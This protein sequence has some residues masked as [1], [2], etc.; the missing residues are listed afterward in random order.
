[1]LSTPPPRVVITALSIIVLVSGFVIFGFLKQWQ[2]M[3]AEGNFFWKA[4]RTPSFINAY[5][6]G[7]TQELAYDSVW[8]NILNLS[9]AGIWGKFGSNLYH[10]VKNWIGSQH[11]ANN[12][13][14]MATILV[15]RFFLRSCPALRRGTVPFASACEKILTIDFRTSMFSSNKLLNYKNLFM[16]ESLRQ[17]LNT[18]TPFLHESRFKIDQLIK[19]N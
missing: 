17:I 14:T 4:F 5:T 19:F 1:M 18:W 16:F 11:Q 15:T 6:N 2:K 7:F 12:K 9:K 8:A 13:M 10:K 3:L